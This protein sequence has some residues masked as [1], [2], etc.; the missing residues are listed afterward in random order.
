MSKAPF[1]LKSGNSP[2]FKQ[3]GSTK[4]DAMSDAELEARRTNTV[5]TESAT[6]DPLE[7][8]RNTSDDATMRGGIWV[9]DTESTESANVEPFKPLYTSREDIKLEKTARKSSGRLNRKERKFEDLALRAESALAEGK[10]R[11]AKRLLKRANRKLRK[12]GVDTTDA[13]VG[14]T[15]DRLIDLDFS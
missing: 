11:K 6:I 1:K 15:S 12:K 8:K 7:G 13:G 4:Y 2:L 5:N 14:K 10:K 9:S 3:M